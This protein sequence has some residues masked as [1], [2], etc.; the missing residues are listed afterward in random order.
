MDDEEVK[1]VPQPEGIAAHQERS[2]TEYEES[3]PLE[4]LWV[5]EYVVTRDRRFDRTVVQK[6]CRGW[7]EEDRKGFMARLTELK[8][9]ALAVEAAERAA[10]VSQEDGGSD[11][12]EELIGQALAR[13]DAATVEGSADG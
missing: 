2:R 13:V 1:K 7:L 8:G 6:Q 3:R 12:L 11:T 9:K 4:L 10:A 5:M